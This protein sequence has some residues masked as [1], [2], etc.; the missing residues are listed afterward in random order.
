MDDNIQIGVNLLKLN[1]P[2]LKKIIEDHGECTLKSSN[3]YFKNL[4]RS[5]IS[6]QLSVNAAKTIYNR[7]LDECKTI[8]PRQ[9]KSQSIENLRRAG[10]SNQKAE[11]IL[12]LANFAIKNP[13]FFKEIEKLPDEEIIIELRKI[14]GIGEWTAQMFLIFSINRLNVLPINDVGFRRSVRKNYSINE[15]ADLDEEILNISKLWGNYRTIA[16]WYLWKSLDNK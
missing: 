11:F 13:K 4:V 12:S 1:D 9:V 8:T 10:L 16:A 6:Q 7:L 5:I 2:V 14:R 15:N 3:S